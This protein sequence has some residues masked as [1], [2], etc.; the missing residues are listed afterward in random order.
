VHGC[1]EG[2]E[3]SP[4]APVPSLPGPSLLWSTNV[5]SEGRGRPGERAFPASVVKRERQLAKKSK[6]PLYASCLYVRGNKAP[7]S[8]SNKL[9]LSNRPDRHGSPRKNNQPG[10]GPPPNTQYTHPGA[11][12]GTGMRVNTTSRRRRPPRPVHHSHNRRGKDGC[13]RNPSP[14]PFPLP[15][16]II[17]SFRPTHV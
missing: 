2:S 12:G 10:S 6:H 1:T 14:R 11:D 9:D 8:I 7:G 17:L 4:P 15:L 16:P 3:S 5:G 13:R